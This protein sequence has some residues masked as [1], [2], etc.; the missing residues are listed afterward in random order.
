[1]SVSSSPSLPVNAATS[2][3]SVSCADGIAK[4]REGRRDG[5]SSCRA[6]LSAGRIQPFPR[7]IGRRT[8]SLRR[9]VLRR[10]Y[11]HGGAVDACPGLDGP[12]HLL[13]V[14]FGDCVDPGVGPLV[15]EMIERAVM[16]AQGASGESASNLRD[17]LTERRCAGRRG[18]K[19]RRRYAHLREQE[20][21]SSDG[22]CS[23]RGW[24]DRHRAPPATRR[25]LAANR[26]SS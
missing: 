16:R 25:R 9:N 3:I 5:L 19:V 8:G 18:D 22:F 14:V 11:R 12:L 2:Q 26:L 1:M 24:R 20:A 6:G 10:S 7:Q 17:D 23:G 15:E 13:Q 4:R 21:G